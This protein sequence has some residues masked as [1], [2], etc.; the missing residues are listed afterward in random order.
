MHTWVASRQQ[1]RESEQSIRVAGSR[2]PSPARGPLG[3]V[4]AR[5]RC[6]SCPLGRRGEVEV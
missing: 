5:S 2:S 1:N 6:R 3:T 4:L